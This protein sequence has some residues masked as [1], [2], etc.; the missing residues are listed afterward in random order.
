MRFILF[1]STVLFGIVSIGNS[2]SIE[3]K[4]GSIECFIV[5]AKTGTP[6]SGSFEILASDAVPIHVTVKGPDSAQSLLFE[7]KFTGVGAL[8]PNESEGSFSFVAESDGDYSMCIANVNPSDGEPR[9]VAF[10]FRALI[11]GEQGIFSVTNF[12]PIFLKHRI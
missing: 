11:T 1:F 5:S 4:P 8:D 10:N 12:R 9:L 7:A 2:Y 6:C 3:V